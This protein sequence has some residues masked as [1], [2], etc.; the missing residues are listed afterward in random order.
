MSPRMNRIKT[1]IVGASGYTG[2]ELLRLLL[3]HPGVELTAAT[4]RAEAGKSL[5]S[6]FP[7][8]AAPHRTALRWRM[9]PCGS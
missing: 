6:V 9:P 5:G 3:T 2:M 7:R 8:F 1:A 4:S